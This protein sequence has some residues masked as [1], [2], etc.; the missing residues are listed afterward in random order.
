MIFS[1]DTEKAFNKIHHSYWRKSGES[2]KRRNVPQLNKG[3][4]Q[5]AYSQ[6]HIKCGKT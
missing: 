3:Y 1:I 2:R 4:V 6:Q 5:Q